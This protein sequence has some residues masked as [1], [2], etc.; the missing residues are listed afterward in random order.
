MM[1]LRHAA[2]PLCCALVLAGCAAAP[3][4]EP[5]RIDAARMN[6]HVS[7]LAGDDMEGRGP[8]SPGEAKAIAYIAAEFEK[9]GLEPVGPDRSWYQKVPLRR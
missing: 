9:I 6:A 3:P 4:S 2:F 8:T 5:A 7:S 1:P